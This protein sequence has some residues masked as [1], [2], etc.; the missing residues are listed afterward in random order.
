MIAALAALPLARPAMA[1]ARA[2]PMPQLRVGDTFGTLLDH[3]AFAG[4]APL[5]LPWDD[6]SADRD[7]AR[8][9]R[10]SAPAGASPMS[11]PWH[12]GF[13]Y[14]VAV[15]AEG[16]N[17]FVLRYRPGA[18]ERAATEDLDAALVPGS[19]GGELR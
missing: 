5:L 9:S 2:V 12:E 10:S 17:A 4:V 8:R 7:P 19:T 16:C 14:A 3:P 11:A 15:N 1:V 18:G 13:P 6:R